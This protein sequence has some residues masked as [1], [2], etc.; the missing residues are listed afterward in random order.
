MAEYT[1]K[2]QE[3][4]REY[5]RYIKL[6]KHLSENTIEGYMQ[7]LSEFAH[8]ILRMY[9]VPPQKVE[10]QMI[11]RYMAWLYD[12]GRRRTSQARRLSGI[13]SFY[14]FLLLGDRIQTLPTEY[15]EAP[16]FGRTLPDVLSTEEVDRIISAVD[17]STAKGRRD[18]A[19]LEVLYS[20]GLR[21]SE[22]T[23]LQVSD[24][25]FGEGYIRV[26]GKGDKQRLVPISATARD[27]IEIYMECRTPRRRTEQT[28]FLNNRGEALTRVMVFTIIKKAALAAGIDKHISPHTFRHSFATHLLQGGANIRQVQ[29]LL[30]HENI[31][32]TE[33]YTHLDRTR[34]RKTIEDKFDNIGDLVVE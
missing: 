1:K 18:S 15:I 17:R 2:W 28:L 26:T 4:A 6:E 14:N 13:K 22:L 33:I 10:S 34:L 11:E 30:G 24:L 12:V 31:M 16:K 7:D 8:F 27:K 29:E 3:T 19:M 25:F 23:S 21:V 9:D 32:T 5:R 20:C